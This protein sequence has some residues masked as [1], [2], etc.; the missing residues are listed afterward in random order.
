MLVELC[1][2]NYVTFDGCVNRVDG[3]FKTSTTYNEI[4]HNLWIMF[5]NA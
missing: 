2:I 1:V 4:N 3:I 5:Q